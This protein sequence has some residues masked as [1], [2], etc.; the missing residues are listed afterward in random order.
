[1]AYGID[2]IGIETDATALDHHR[3]FIE[4]WAKRSRLP[5]R[6]RSFRP[7]NAERRHTSIR[8]AA[9]RAELKAGG[10]TTVETFAADGG[11]RPIL[12]RRSVDLIVV[13]LPYGIQHRGAG[14]GAD[15]TGELLDRLL[16]V[17][18]TWLRPGGAFCMAWNTRRLGRLDASLLVV[19]A[20]LELVEPSAP[21][22][23]AHTVDAT[24]ERDVI[25]AVT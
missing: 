12:P 21:C 22:S 11:D 24:I 2:S 9:D 5:H 8:I 15:D 3:T 25:V 13:D 6:A 18:R 14:T 7:G 17:W 20:G 4:Q 1:M 23:L 19:D 16:P 10:G